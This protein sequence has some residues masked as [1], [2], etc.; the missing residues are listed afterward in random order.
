MTRYI[1]VTLDESDG[2]TKFNQLT[3]IGPTVLVEFRFAANGDRHSRHS[4]NTLVRARRR[5]IQ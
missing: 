1:S 2:P 5:L 4:W 3:R